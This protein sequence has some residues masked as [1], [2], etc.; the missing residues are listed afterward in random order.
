MSWVKHRDKLHEA[1]LSSIK[2]V[3]K[4]KTLTSK[5]GIPQRPPSFNQAILTSTPRSTKDLPSWRGEA[6]FQA[7]WYL[8][9]KTKPDVDISMPARIVFNELEMS[10]VEILG[11]SYYKGSQTNITEYLKTINIDDKKSPHYL[12]LCSNLWLK[13]ACGI[14]LSTSLKKLLKEFNEACSKLGALKL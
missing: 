1:A 9:H 2:S 8:F 4:I 5:N 12:A 6:D 3:S 14:H 7:F 10:R 13:D 11:S